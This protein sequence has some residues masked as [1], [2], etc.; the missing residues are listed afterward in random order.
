MDLCMEKISD[1]FLIRERVAGELRSNINAG[2]TQTLLG[3]KDTL[4]EL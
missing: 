2:T 4:L 3:F 1:M